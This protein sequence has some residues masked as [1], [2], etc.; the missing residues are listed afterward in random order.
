MAFLKIISIDKSVQ[1]VILGKLGNE[2]ASTTLDGAVT[3][4]DTVISVTS[5][6]GM[7]VGDSFF[8][9]DIANFI[10]EQFKI[11]AINTNDITV[12]TPSG[13]DIE[14]GIFVGSSNI[15]FNVDG[16]STPVK[17]NLKTGLES[18]DI[19]LLISRVII[20]MET[21]STSAINQ[22]GNIT[23]LT[24]GIYLRK[25]T[26]NG[27]TTYFNAK[28]NLEL[29]AL[30]YDLEGFPSGVSGNDGIRFRLTFTKMGSFIELGQGE[31]LELWIQDDLEALVNAFATV[32]GVIKI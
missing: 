29:V 5:A 21:A 6:A 25:T 23:A 22:F 2:K 9:I 12:D 26:G 10:V 32:E 4:D 27:A 31:D 28:S 19:T 8:V 14:S 16:S 20:V 17:F 7:S 3:K 11:L 24:N 18:A 1:P 30:G 15:N 13:S